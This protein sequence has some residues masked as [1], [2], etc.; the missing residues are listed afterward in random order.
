MYLAA[1]AIFSGDGGGRTP[2]PY[3]GEAVCIAVNTVV[4]DL[5]VGKRIGGRAF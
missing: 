5:K 2:Y 1:A 4:N 3:G